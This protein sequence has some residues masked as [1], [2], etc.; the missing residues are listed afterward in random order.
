MAV[1]HDPDATARL[2]GDLAAFG[3]RMPPAWDGARV[4][5][6]VV[7]PGARYVGRV[8]PGRGLYLPLDAREIGLRRLP[9]AVYA[10][11]PVAR[12][13]ELFDG[14]ERLGIA[15]AGSEDDARALRAL[16]LAVGGGTI[17]RYD[18]IIN[19]RMAG[20]AYDRAITKLSITTVANVWFSLFS[21]AGGLPVAGTYTAIPGGAATNNASTGAWSYGLPNPTAP[22]VMALLSFGFM[23]TQQINTLMLADLLV[24][25][26]SILQTAASNTVNSTA[27]TRYTDGAGVMMTYETTTAA[28][29]TAQNMTVTYT[30]QAGNGSASSGAQ[31]MTASAIVGRLQPSTLTPFTTLASGDYGV[32]SVQ[33]VAFSATNTAGQVAL[34]LLFPLMLVPGVAAN[35]YVER[36]STVQIDGVTQLV[37]E[38]GGALGCLTGYIFPNTTTSGQ[39]VAQMRTCAG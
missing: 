39:L 12:A 3:R 36:D 11:T 14:A 1:A 2:L 15:A 34:N 13:L 5:I 27:L 7:L 38:A 24:A 8:L 6:P 30:D 17:A 29:A 21:Q 10:R 9:P 25:A 33:T 18:D 37:T 16:R 26:G 23:S 20:K 32:R 35:V 4:S 19:A 22:D 28:G 31:A